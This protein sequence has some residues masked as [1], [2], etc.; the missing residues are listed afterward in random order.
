M[1]DSTAPETG[2]LDTNP[3]EHTAQPAERVV[4]GFLFSL[5]I[6]PLGVILWV[7][8]WQL[9]YVAAFVA[10][11]IVLG[12]AFLYRLGSGGRVSMKGLFVILGVTVVTIVLAFLA[13]VAADIA[14]FLGMSLIPALG[15][16][17]FWD[18]FAINIFDNP[19]MWAEYMPDII[20][21][22]IFAAVGTVGVIWSIFKEAR[23]A[24]S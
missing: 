15:N 16:G 21:T 12:A 1:T 10:L 14:S 6:I 17:E 24:R 8:I 9:G 2:D 5:A 22:V 13:G 7:V 11:A 20:M 18:T 4:R 19:E 23:A 3:E